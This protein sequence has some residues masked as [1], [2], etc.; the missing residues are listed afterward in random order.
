LTGAD[1][2]DSYSALRAA[3]AI[4]ATLMLLAG[5]AAPHH[6]DA[7]LGSHECLACSVG[8]A[9]EARDVTPRPE[10][11]AASPGRVAIEPGLPP[12]TGAPL[13]AVPGQSPPHA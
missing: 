7:P 13:G 8:G 3:L 6:H 11:P 9:G 1:P 10:R 4:L 2:A 12:V 5:L